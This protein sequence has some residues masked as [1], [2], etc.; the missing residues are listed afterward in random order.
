MNSARKP[1]VA[2]EKLWRQYV[3]EDIGSQ[4]FAWEV[5]KEQMEQLKTFPP[6]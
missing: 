4:R 5:V 1:N 2:T 6:I 3:T